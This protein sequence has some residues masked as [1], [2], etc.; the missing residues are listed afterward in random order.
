MRVWSVGTGPGR[1]IQ[2]AL[3]QPN[4][5]RPEC[6]ELTLGFDAFCCQGGAGFGGEGNKAGH[7]GLASG[8]VVEVLDQDAI[9]LDDLGLPRE[10]DAQTFCGGPRLIGGDAQ[11]EVGADAPASGQ[12]VVIPPSS[13][14]V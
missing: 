7:Q 9:D 10:Q 12:C 3:R 11:T 13:T 1:A 2:V 5:Q 14:S 6:G 8:I 4:A